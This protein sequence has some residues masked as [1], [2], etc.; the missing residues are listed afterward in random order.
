MISNLP[1]PPEPV[2]VK[3]RFKEELENGS[4]II[5]GNIKQGTWIATPLWN[6]FGWGE[7]LKSHMVTW[8]IFMKAVS[9]NYYSFIAWIKDRKSWADTI[10]DL[11]DEIEEWRREI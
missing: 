11:I 3:Q 6:E 9:N 8:Q 10:S 2:S 4:K 1:I 5:K 7:I